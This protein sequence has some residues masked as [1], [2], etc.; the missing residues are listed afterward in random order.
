MLFIGQQHLVFILSIT[1]HS[2]TT[3]GSSCS[4]LQTELPGLSLDAMQVYL[5]LPISKIFT[6]MNFLPLKEQIYWAINI[7]CFSQAMN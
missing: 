6:S 4:S 2:V 7:P 5:L 3:V 1:D